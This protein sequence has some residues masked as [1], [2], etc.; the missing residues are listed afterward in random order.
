MD[1]VETHELPSIRVEWESLL[2][3]VRG[4]TN[5]DEQLRPYLWV[6]TG[7]I[8]CPMLLGPTQTQIL[9]ASARLLKIPVWDA[10]EG[11]RL[12]KEFAESLC[13]GSMAKQA[14]DALKRPQPFEAFDGVLSCVPIEA[15]R[16]RDE[17]RL[18]AATLI[19]D[20]LD[21][22]GYVPEPTPDLERR[23]LEFPIRRS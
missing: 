16:W 13:D 23:I 14:L 1:S 20:W 2:D 12:R 19:C 9:M 5:E 11:I 3:A 10:K 15:T 4:P 7:Q 6:D 17:E 22:E 18:A 8:T 21:T